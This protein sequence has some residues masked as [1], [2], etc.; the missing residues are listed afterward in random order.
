MIKKILPFLGSIVAL[1][2]GI[3]AQSNSIPKPVAVRW[4]VGE[5]GKGLGDEA[6][7]PR[8]VQ[9]KNEAVKAS[10]SINIK[11]V[12][13]IAFDMI[14]QKRAENGLGALA[15][16]DQLE[17]LARSH[18]EDMAQFDYFSHRSRDGKVVSDRAD[19]NGIGK[20]RA[21]GENIAFNRGFADPIAKAVDLWLNSPSHRTN[22]MSSSWKESAV[23]VAVAPDGSYYFTQVFLTRK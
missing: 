4:I 7:R 22:L 21:I 13:R 10:V 6:E 17:G 9:P 3:H 14:N 23:G 16:S 1:S 8:I 12:E 11:S 2:A 5:T 15:W 18:S 20:W 19:D